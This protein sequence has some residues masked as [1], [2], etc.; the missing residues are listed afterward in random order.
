MTTAEDVYGAYLDSAAIAVALLADPAVA[1]AWDQP[2]ALAE[3]T[4]RGLAGHPAR[5]VIVVRELLAAEPPAGEGVSLLDHY[6]RAQWVGASLDHEANVMARRSGEAAA[7]GGAAELVRGT[8]A[9]LAELRAILPG[10]PGDRLV[11]APGGSR[12]GECT[13]PPCSRHAR[14]CDFEHATPYD[15]GG[16][17]CACN[18]GARS[19]RCHR[20]K[21]SRGW[22]VTQP[23][24]GWHQCITPA[25]RTY[26]RGPMQYPA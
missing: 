18:A 7:A 12:D 16:K 1:A 17:T 20:V 21:Q 14:N 6:A 8:A 22:T 13:F 5:Q 3:F 9:A 26:I 19:R 24:P 23:W 15:Q 2:S 10:Q 4:V 11:V 25:G